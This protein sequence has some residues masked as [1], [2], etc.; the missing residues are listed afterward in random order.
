MRTVIVF[1]VGLAL[2]VAVPAPLSH[3]EEA[4]PQPKKEELMKK[5]LQHSQK[6]LEGIATNDFDLIAKSAEELIAISKEAQWKTIKTPRY[7][8]YSEDFQ[9][10]AGTLVDDA[11]KKNIDAATLTYMELTMTCVKCHKHV[12][13]VRDAE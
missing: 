9:R 1:L 3:A 7:T 2:V 8:L 6:V 10:A 13:E 11:K 4:L 12:R 5:K